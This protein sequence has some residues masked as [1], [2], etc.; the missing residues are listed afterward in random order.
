MLRNKIKKIAGVALL[1]VTIIGISGTVQA[2]ANNWQDT[3]F[4][5]NFNNSQKYTAARP[6]TDTSK[7]YMKCESITPNT[8]YTAHA[9][10]CTSASS[11]DRVDC[12]KGNSYSFSKAG[13]AHYMTSWVKEWNYGYA[14]IAGNPNYGYAFSASGKWSPDNK[15]GL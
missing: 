5:F 7:L 13:D 2:N 14:R 11:S 6:K 12:S 1:S 10:G 8:S 3:N 9:I 4:T 15:A